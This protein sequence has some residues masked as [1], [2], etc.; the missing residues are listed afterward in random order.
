MGGTGGPVRL[1]LVLEIGLKL[2]Q[3]YQLDIIRLETFGEL[4][5]S[6][7]ANAPILNDRMLKLRQ[8]YFIFEDTLSKL[9]D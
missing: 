1:Q 3:R 6:E 9:F 5:S 7:L 4:F 8:D 2:N